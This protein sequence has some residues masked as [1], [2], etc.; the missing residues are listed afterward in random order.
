M[1]LLA[2]YLNLDSILNRSKKLTKFKQLNNEIWLL[3]ELNSF[4]TSKLDKQILWIW[5]IRN[6]FA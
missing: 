1:L 2:L 3:K 4:E 6:N 5:L